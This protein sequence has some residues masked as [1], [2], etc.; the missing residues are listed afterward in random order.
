MHL[1]RLQVHC[2]PSTGC[3][4]LIKNVCLLMDEG[5]LVWA[6]P[7]SFLYIP[8]CRRSPQSCVVTK[9]AAETL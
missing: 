9:T 1:N 8:S 4:W 7:L 6:A 3:A 5:A 2:E